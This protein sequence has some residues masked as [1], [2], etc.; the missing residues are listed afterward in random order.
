MSVSTDFE[1]AKSHKMK[2]TTNIND[3]SFKFWGFDMLNIGKERVCLVSQATGSDA[4]GQP[5]LA[6]QLAGRSAAAVNLGIFAEIVENGS[7]W[8]EHIA[9]RLFRA[10]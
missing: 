1:H 8:L 5:R 10:S 9:K 6:G 2:H 3:L 7:K 4:A